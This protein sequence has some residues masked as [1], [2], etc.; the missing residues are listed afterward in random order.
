M[1]SMLRKPRLCGVNWYSIPGLPSPTISFTLQLL[2][3][4]LQLS[5]LTVE[6]GLAPSLPDQKTTTGLLLF[7][8]LGLLRLLCLLGTGLGGTFLFGLLLALLDDLGFG[9]S[10]SRFRCC[11]FRSGRHFFFDGYD[12]RHRL[13]L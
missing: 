4:S 12:V 1:R 6:T 9:R 3:V 8:L 10:G 2:A 7:L 11:G 13:V 5:A